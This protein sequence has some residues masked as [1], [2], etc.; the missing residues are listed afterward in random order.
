LRAATRGRY[1]V[2]ILTHTS[3]AGAAGARTRGPTVSATEIRDVIR[4][5]IAKVCKIDTAP[6]RDEVS[7][8]E[9]LGL[10]SLAFLETLV[11]VQ[12]RFQIVDVLDEDVAA[13]RTVGDAVGLVRRHAFTEAA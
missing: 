9:D 1:K 13:V 11:E 6:L 3:A 7:F 12:Y 2:S 5:A 4:E 8:R 10:D